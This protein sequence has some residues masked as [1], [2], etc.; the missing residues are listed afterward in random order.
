MRDIAERGG[1]FKHSF[2]SGD[3]FRDTPLRSGDMVARHGG[4]ARGSGRGV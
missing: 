4:S 3:E 1:A 2:A